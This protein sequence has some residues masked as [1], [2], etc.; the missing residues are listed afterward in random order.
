MTGGHP[1]S[2]RHPQ[3]GFI[4]FVVDGRVDG[5]V[6]I[7]LLSPHTHPQMGFIKFVFDGR[8]DGFVVIPLLSPA[9]GLHQVRGQAHLRN[10]KRGLAC[11]EACIKLM[12]L[13]ERALACGEACNGRG[14]A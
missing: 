4:K 8:V 3:M 6:V 13:C 9:D 14:L 12:R 11:G 10:L 5:F 1:S 2:T 7:P